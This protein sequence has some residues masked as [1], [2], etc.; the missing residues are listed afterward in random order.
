MARTLSRTRALA[1]AL[2]A[3]AACE[4]E[5]VQ[6]DDLQLVGALSREELELKLDAQF[7]SPSSSSH[8]WRLVDP[9]ARRIR[10]S[11]RRSRVGTRVPPLSL[12]ADGHQEGRWPPPAR[13]A[14][15]RDCANC[16]SHASNTRRPRSPFYTRPAH[17]TAIT[18]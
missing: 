14:R 13:Q 17:T 18:A 10:R 1:F 15:G 9:A 2:L 8:V 5:E 16:A 11:L 4:E 7:A 3:L 6:Q 12:D